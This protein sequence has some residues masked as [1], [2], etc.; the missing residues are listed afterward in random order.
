M[1]QPSVAE[2][3]ALSAT[4]S[5]L[6]L[7]SLAVFCSWFPRDLSLTR[8]VYLKLRVIPPGCAKG[9]QLT[10]KCTA[11]D[12]QMGAGKS[13]N[14]APTD[15]PAQQ[16]SQTAPPHAQTVS[17]SAETTLA[18]AAS[19]SQTSEAQQTM[20]ASAS[21]QHGSGPESPAS[22]AA[23]PDAYKCPLTKQLIVDPVVDPEVWSYS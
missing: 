6:R 5:F 11:C 22:G 18:T 2:F 8:S 4:F 16:T 10:V 7:L 21:A 20:S 23:E 13:K 17:P 15:Q 9:A 12:R 19:V 14:K 3:A 1:T